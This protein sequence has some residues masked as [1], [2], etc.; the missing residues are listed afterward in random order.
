V[1][2]AC[3]DLL[4][5]AARYSLSCWA[6]PGV[7]GR[8]GRRVLLRLGIDVDLP[9]G[10]LSVAYD[11][12][13]PQ[14]RHIGYWHL[15]RD[16]YLCDHCLSGNPSRELDWLAAR[17]R[18]EAPDGRLHS[19]ERIWKHAIDSTGVVDRQSDGL[20]FASRRLLVEALAI[21]PRYQCLVTDALAEAMVLQSAQAS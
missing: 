3:R 7:D 18:I 15:L 5:D 12:F 6:H 17:L 20:S 2:A 8:I 11:T 13:L 4:C 16:A 9:P 21:R 19:W 10:R 14:A 1:T